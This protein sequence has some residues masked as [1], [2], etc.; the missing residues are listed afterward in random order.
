M[1]ITSCDVDCI[2][3][4]DTRGARQCPLQAAMWTIS[5]PGIPEV[6]G[7]CLLLIAN[8]YMEV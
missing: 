5:I 4:L 7:Q 2:H 1:S 6:Q 8:H 3:F